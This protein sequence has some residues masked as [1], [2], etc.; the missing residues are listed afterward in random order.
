[1]FDVYEKYA[2]VL[3]IKSALGIRTRKAYLGK[4]TRALKEI[5]CDYDTLSDRL[6]E[7]YASYKSEWFRENK[8]HGFDVQDIRLGG[9]MRRVQ[10]CKERLA[11]FI[12]GKIN[13]IPELSEPVLE[14]VGYEPWGRLFSANVITFPL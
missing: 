5:I 3:E 11:N 14:G 2:K 7:F 12:D 10:S 1:M 13:E 6:E 9:L 8:P 4:D